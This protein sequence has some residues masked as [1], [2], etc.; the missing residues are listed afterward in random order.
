MTINLDAE[1]AKLFTDN[2]YTKEQVSSTVN[3]Y[4][5]QGLSDDQIQSKIND[6][7]TTLQGSVSYGESPFEAIGKGLAGIPSAVVQGIGDVAGKVVQT[8]QN[9]VE[10]PYKTV[11]ATPEAFAGGI[12]SGVENL[13]LGAY[14]LPG[15]V[16]N[17]FGG[18][19]A[20]TTPEQVNT[21]LAEKSPYAKA[22]MERSIEQQKMNPL[23]SLGGNIVPYAVGAAETGVLK[24]VPTVAGKL[25]TLGAIGTPTTKASERITSAGANAVLSPEAGMGV[26]KAGKAIKG[27]G[28]TPTTPATGLSA[29]SEALREKLT[30]ISP[31][32]YNRVL[33]DIK[34][35]FVLRS[36]KGKLIVNQ[37]TA[38]LVGK[39][40]VE[41][42]LGS[43]Y[44][45]KHL[46]RAN[47]PFRSVIE[48]IEEDYNIKDAKN[49]VSNIS[50]NLADELR[51]AIKDIK[52]EKGKAVEEAV[53]ELPKVDFVSELEGTKAVKYSVKDI[54][55]GLNNIINEY[56]IPGLN[57]NTA[58]EGASKQVR[59]FLDKLNNLPED[60]MLSLGDLHNYKKI[61]DDKTNFDT[62]T[63]NAG[64]R[65]Q[66]DLR[67]YINDKI[68]EKNT[69]YSIANDQ[70][71]ELIRFLKDNKGIDKETVANKL[72]NMD[73]TTTQ[74]KLFKEQLDKLNN[75]LPENKQVN[76]ERL[77]EA[78]S[79]LETVKEFNKSTFIKE[80]ENLTD[81]KTPLNDKI[82]TL[83]KLEESRV[84]SNK[85]Y[86]VLKNKLAYAKIINE[87][88]VNVKGSHP[89][90]NA[91]PVENLLKLAPAIQ[92]GQLGVRAAIKEYLA[93]V[94]YVNKETGNVNKSKNKLPKV[95]RTLFSQ[96]VSSQTSNR[97]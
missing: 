43:K 58:L 16:A 3:H 29:L 14:N 88:S 11:L 32:T 35:T 54:K 30:G 37:G 63:S 20:P 41:N 50:M 89:T 68:R 90:I 21:A 95:P 52:S 83:D 2:G 34:N 64:N 91:G 97:K 12:A 23:F 56:R 40:P 15:T 73:L 36:A 17:V 61:I 24:A 93:K 59:N 79:D 1:Q 47:E 80:L 42:I 18:N 10:H 13:A 28:S 86:K 57:Y 19:V 96:A 69:T 27:E 72:S 71:S 60:S 9:L 82:T 53:S 7:I 87:L 48:L 62:T 4:R 75:V 49:I 65:L 25:A 84:I 77:N 51:S 70:Y 67:K 81:P 5:S 66:K 38:N 85:D 22:V 45:I 46:E 6:K 76:I 55:T 33:S 94:D 26:L 44:A 8:G 31:E 74:G 92:R 78:K 39:N